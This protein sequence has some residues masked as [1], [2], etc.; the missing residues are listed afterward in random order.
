MRTSGPVS[1][2]GGRLRAAVGVGGELMITLG[3]VLLLFVVY[4]VYW[5]NVISAGKQRDATAELDQR[6]ADDP[7]GQQRS[8]RFPVEDG[9]GIAKL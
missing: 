5:T 7:G 4:E 2:R 9:K 6:W 1:S 3:L 8:L